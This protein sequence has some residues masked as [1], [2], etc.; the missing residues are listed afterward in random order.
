MQSMISTAVENFFKKLIQNSRKNATQFLPAQIPALK[1]IFKAHKLTLNEREAH[2]SALS[3]TV[4]R[5]TPHRTHHD[6]IMCVCVFVLNCLFY[7]AWHI[8]LQE[9]D[10]WQL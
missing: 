10:N 6:S 3:H 1:A 4:S 7:V 9:A 8:H 5:P 2:I